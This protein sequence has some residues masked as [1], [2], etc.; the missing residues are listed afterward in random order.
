MLEYLCSISAIRLSRLPKR[1][2]TPVTSMNTPSLPSVA[3]HGPHLRAQS[4]SWSRKC[5]SVSEADKCVMMVGSK[6]RASVS[7]IPGDI[8]ALCAS[9]FTA[10]MMIPCV[11]SETS[12]RARLS[13]CGCVL[14]QRSI[15]SIGNQIE[16]ICRSIITEI[17]CARCYRT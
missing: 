17:P 13:C 15:A 9:P 14:V 11:P 1:W 16:T 7:R 6:A 10:S 4:A 2:G 3:V 5:L 8:P 12:A